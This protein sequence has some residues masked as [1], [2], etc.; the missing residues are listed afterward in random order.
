MNFDTFTL[1]ILIAVNLY[2][3]GLMI[4]LIISD[5]QQSEYKNDTL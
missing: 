5:K 4:K 3:W 1:T 2:T